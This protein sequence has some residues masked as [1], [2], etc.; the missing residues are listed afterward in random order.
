MG[1]NDIC[2]CCEHANKNLLNETGQFHGM[3][4]VC[5][6]FRKDLSRKGVNCYVSCGL[7]MFLSFLNFFIYLFIC[8]GTRPSLLW[9]TA[10]QKVICWYK[11]LK[12]TGKKSVSN[13]IAWNILNFLDSSWGLRSRKNFETKIPDLWWFWMLS[14]V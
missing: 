1:Q 11:L 2:H 3:E 4:V 13:L 7:W 6:I 8:G 10:H 14:D 12:F 5:T 9:T